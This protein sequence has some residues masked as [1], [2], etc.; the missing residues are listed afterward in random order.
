MARPDQVGAHPL[1]DA[2]KLL[3]AGGA[4]AVAALFVIAGAANL[5]FYDAFG[6]QDLRV[7]GIDKSA[8]I[9][10]TIIFGVVLLAV[11]GGLFAFAVGVAAVARSDVA[12]FKRRGTWGTI[13]QWMLALVV[14][15][16]CGVVVVKTTRADPK[17]AAAAIVLLAAAYATIA[18][19]R[20]V[21]AS[22]AARPVRWIA[23]AAASTTLFAFAAFSQGAAWG[24]AV[25]VL[26]RTNAP[27]LGHVLIVQWPHG[28]VLD[29]SGPDPAST[30]CTEEIV[31]ARAGGTYVLYNA[32]IG[33][34]HEVPTTQRLTRVGL[35]VVRRSGCPG[36]AGPASAR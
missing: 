11:F 10:H 36:P 23:G 7:V 18:H 27:L 32:R 20:R 31:L 19:A 28:A 6:I 1:H 14:L 21:A 17:L 8:V 16:G 34:A 29:G 12:P 30:S 24:S 13:A 26:D 15:L 5:G 3:G 22:V 9:D 33:R 2:L 35:G 25:R 4:A